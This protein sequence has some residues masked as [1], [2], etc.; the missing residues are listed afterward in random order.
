MGCYTIYNNG[1]PGFNSVVCK[2][3]M[4]LYA[5]ISNADVK[6]SNQTANSFE[7]IEL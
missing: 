2:K 5:R 6:L 7:F 4:A 3:Y 1:I